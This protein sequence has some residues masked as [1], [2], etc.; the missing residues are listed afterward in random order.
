MA[1]GDLVFSRVPL[2][3]GDL[4]FGEGDDAPAVPDVTL[5]AS[6][7]VTGL[8]G[9]ITAR[10][11]VLV[12]ATG[13]VTGLRGHFGAI[14]DNNVSRPTVGQVQSLWQDGAAARRPL[15]SNYQQALTLSSGHRLR[16]QDAARLQRSTRPVWQLAMPLPC[17]V[18]S[19]WQ[20]AARL[21]LVRRSHWQT[22]QALR[23][24]AS[25]SWQDAVR[26][27]KSTE[28]RFQ[29][30]LR[31]RRISVRTHWQDGVPHVMGVRSSEGYGL[32][33]L[34]SHRPHWQDAWVPRPG[35]S[36]APQPPL[37]EPCYLPSGHL[38][39][40]APWL[41]DGNLVFICERH[42]PP[43]PGET[44]VVPVRRVYIVINDVSLR[45][46]DGNIPL[47]CSKLTLSLDMDSWAWSFS[48][49]LPGSALT[50]LEPGFNGAPAELEAMVNGTAFRVLV[51]SISRERVF[52]RVTLRVQGRGKTALL[53]TPYSPIMNFSSAAPR[54][55]QQLM[56]DV[57]TVNGSAMDWLVDWQLVDWLVPAD[58]WAHQGS[59]I[60]ALNTIAKA[61]GGYVQPHAS[62]Q[63]LHILSRYP[64]AP[65]EWATEITPDFELPSAVVV[66]EGIEWLEKAR[67]NQVYVSGQQ[68]GVLREVIRTGTA[69]DLGA[70]MVVDT[71]ITH[72]DAARQRGISILSDVG[73]QAN[74]SISLPVLPE[75]GIITPGKF[76]RYTDAS[77]NRLGIVRSTSVNMETFPTV[78]Q[79]LGVQ[80][81]A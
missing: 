13:K 64:K 49:E 5:S 17:A 14:Y 63:T 6:G 59:Y 73:R 70:P 55:A 48:A 58:V 43:T 30:A 12:Q 21:H 27:H 57:L 9:R 25:T 77:T 31:D 60:S 1:A 34:H 15:L 4:V 39:F 47:D 8:R 67:Y 18:A 37:P 68:Q 54:T 7:K 79:L 65:W 35:T 62:L 81:Y 69:G 74:V 41:A 80:T 61:A 76:V 24:A 72:D 16:W 33:L 10:A 28:M 20:D 3:T 42:T 36:A 32:R 44:V 50:N 46:V 22:G 23:Q 71:L 78:R 26:L 53:D 19:R 40:E 52:P 38:V 29:E 66:R 75:T 51:E 56:G 45:R 2:T 11:G